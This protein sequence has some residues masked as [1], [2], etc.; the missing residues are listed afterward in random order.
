VC[1][2]VG[3]GDWFEGNRYAS[4]RVGTHFRLESNAFRAG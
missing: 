2:S 4:N 1:V 3:V